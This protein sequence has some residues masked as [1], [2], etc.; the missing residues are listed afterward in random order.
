LLRPL[1]DL[2]KPDKRTSVDLWTFE[3]PKT[4]FEGQ[5]ADLAISV[6]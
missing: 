1:L 3:Q 4:L 5:N 2:A 6:A